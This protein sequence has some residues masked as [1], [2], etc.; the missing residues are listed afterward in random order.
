[1]IST[2]PR[3]TLRFRARNVAI[4]VGMLLLAAGFVAGIV[5]LVGN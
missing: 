5:R 1:M 3:W 4:W 2:K